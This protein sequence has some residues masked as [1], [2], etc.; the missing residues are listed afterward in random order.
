MNVP[1]LPKVHKPKWAETLRKAYNRDKTRR[2]QAKRCYSTDSATWLKLRAEVL[3]HEPLCRHC[4][5]EGRLTTAV[6][7]DHIDGDTFNNA[8]SNLQS[9]C[10]SCH[11]KKTVRE[12]GGFLT[13]SR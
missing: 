3:R 13:G 6:D 7:V 10:R 4:L 12:N 5:K 9:L 11:A 1:E 2:N 8:A